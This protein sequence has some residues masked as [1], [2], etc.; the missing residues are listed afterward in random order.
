MQSGGNGTPKSRACAGEL[1]GRCGVAVV[2]D[3]IFNHCTE[4]PASAAHHGEGSAVAPRT[5]SRLRSRTITGSPVPV[6]GEE[7]ACDALLV[8]GSGWDHGSPPRPEHRPGPSGMPRLAPAHAPCAVAPCAWACFGYSHT[9]DWS[10][11][12]CSRERAE[13]AA[14]ATSSSSRSKFQPARLPEPIPH[15]VRPTMEEP[16]M[17]M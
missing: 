12:S 14:R 15:Q 1:R 8:F 16:L 10:E 17:C 6:L 2:G 11:V 9:R 5:S 7:A 13:S 3:A 4:I